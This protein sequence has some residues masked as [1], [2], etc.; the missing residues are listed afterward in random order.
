[1]CNDMY[2]TNVIL[3]L[4]AGI[5]QLRQ[6]WLQVM[7]QYRPPSYFANNFTTAVSWLI[8]INLAKTFVLV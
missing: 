4:A 7:G 6:F 8:W 1:M 5:Q 2:N 3:D